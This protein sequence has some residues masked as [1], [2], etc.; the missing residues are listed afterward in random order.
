MYAIYR[1]SLR[2]GKEVMFGIFE[3]KKSAMDYMWEAEMRTKHMT[4]EWICRPYFF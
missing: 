2:T 1:R 4:I 3:T